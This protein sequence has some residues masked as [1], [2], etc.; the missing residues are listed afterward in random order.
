MD[1]PKESTEEKAM[2]QNKSVSDLIFDK[3]ADLVKSDTLFVDISSELEIAVRLE[4]PK[5]ADIIKVLQKQIPK[6]Q[7]KTEET[8]R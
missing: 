8:A 6:V 4:K 1:I 5:K 7:D 2:I 3:F